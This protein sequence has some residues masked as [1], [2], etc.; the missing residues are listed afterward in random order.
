MEPQ[1][2]L[3]VLWPEDVEAAKT[4]VRPAAGDFSGDFVVPLPMPAS[5]PR[6]RCAFPACFAPAVYVCGWWPYVGVDRRLGRCCR[7]Y[8]A[9][10]AKTHAARRR[11]R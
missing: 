11:L 2:V 10:H 8:C 1:G 9:E 4:K 6:S 7:K 3:G 5:G